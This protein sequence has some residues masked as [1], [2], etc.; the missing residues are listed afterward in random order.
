MVPNSS[1][2]VNR[3]LLEMLNHLGNILNRLAK[4][5]VC[6]PSTEINVYPKKFQLKQ[7]NVSNGNK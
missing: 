2:T 3:R 7:G 1:S 4:N 6:F 5:P